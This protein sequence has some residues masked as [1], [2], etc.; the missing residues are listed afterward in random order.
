MTDARDPR[1][2]GIIE[3]LVSFARQDF[4]QRA[5]ISDAHDEVDAIAVGLNMLAEELHGA[6]A[7][8]A[9]LSAAYDALKQ[10]QARLLHHGKLVAIGELASGVAHEINNPATWVSLA[11][12]LMRQR[13]D[14]VVKLAQEPLASREKLQRALREMS[15]TL[16]DAIEGM[17]RIR[18]VAGDLRTYSRA[19]GDATERL[20]VNDVV[21]AAWRLARPS[22]A[23]RGRTTLWLA[24]ENPWVLG[25][26]GRL[27]QVVTNLLVN[28]AHA[29]GEGRRP[30]DEVRTYTRAAGEHVLVVVEDSGPGVPFELREKVFEP[31]FTTK[32]ANEGTG[33]GL[34]LVAE[35]VRGHGGT[36]RITESALGGA[37]FEVCLPRVPA[38]QVGEKPNEKPVAPQ[39]RLRILI[40]DDE[41]KL[42]TTYRMLLAPDHEVV[43]AASGAQALE[44]VSADPRFDV[45][46]CDLQMPGMDG[47]D[48]FE[49]VKAKAPALE[50][51]FVFST[52]GGVQ[53]RIRDFVEST[54]M[55][56]LEKPVRLEKLLETM[57]KVTGAT[58]AMPA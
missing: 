42:L 27:A 2:D 38:A 49:Q 21:E 58:L 15:G 14:E 19:D 17:E 48:T 36:V 29:L 34:S 53:R 55:P 12:T 28:A 8:R 46:L 30:S 45:V 51:R 4:A 23:E 26:R 47:V 16:G 6:V 1:I 37:A 31:F 24:A 40:I 56:I 43:T 25:N 54:T 33:L 57:G 7:S 9:E 44:V 35:I 3:V 50:N 52:G 20:P 10:A 39:Q 18:T 22:L 11:L 41:P 13:L 5:P 32:P